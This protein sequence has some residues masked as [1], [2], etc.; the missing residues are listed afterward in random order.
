MGE[1]PFCFFR[2]TGKFQ[3]DYR[4]ITKPQ[5]LVRYWC[6]V[7]SAAF[8]AWP[9]N[10]D[11]YPITI[12]GPIGP[13]STRRRTGQAT[14]IRDDHPLCLSRTLD[15][16]A[17]AAPMY[18]NEI[19]SRARSRRCLP[20]AVSITSHPPAWNL[21]LPPFYGQAVHLSSMDGSSTAVGS[22]A[23]SMTTTGRT[24]SQEKALHCP[25]A[26]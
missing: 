11:R 5:R 15:G 4:E 7:T 6:I 2:G 21:P 8:P 3:T 24:P 12:Y 20:M 13:T 14:R 22:P 9:A 10:H 25:T 16:P 19:S 17:C 26:H 23:T 18:P 1:L